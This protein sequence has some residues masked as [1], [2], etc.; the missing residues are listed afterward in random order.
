MSLPEN[1]TTVN[2][3]SASFV[4]IMHLH[5]G[6]THIHSQIKP[7]LPLESFTLMGNHKC[8]PNFFNVR[9]LHNA[10]WGA[11]FNNCCWHWNY[12][13]RHCLC[14]INEQIYLWK[15]PIWCNSLMKQYC[16]PQSHSPRQQTTSA[17]ANFL[18]LILWINN[19]TALLCS[20]YCSRYLT[21]SSF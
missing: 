6:L 10:R 15:K 17:M 20:F 9:K 5:K 16:C 19:T 13:R 4:I 8:F 1:E 2:I 11:L 21:V 18:Y 7:V 12:T 3:K 14:G